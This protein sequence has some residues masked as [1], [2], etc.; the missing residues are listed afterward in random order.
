MRWVWLA[1]AA[2]FLGG[3]WAWRLRPPD[4]AP[5]E[6]QHRALR[7]PTAEEEGGFGSRSASTTQAARE[8]RSFQQDR[9]PPAAGNLSRKTP[10]A[11][12]PWSA[13]PAQRGAVRE[14]LAP[15]ESSG[16]AKA[17]A[18]GA[19]SG[20]L[21][22]REEPRAGGVP[23]EAARHAPPK[24]TAAPGE[25]PGAGQGGTG[26]ALAGRAP[27]GPSEGAG[28]GPQ[29]ERK[30][31]PPAGEPEPQESG[32][33]DPGPPAGSA[34]SAP[35]LGAALVPPRPLYAPLPEHPGTKVE[36]HPSGGFTAASAV[37]REGRV[38]VRLLVKA[39]GSVAGVDILASSGDSELDRA[40][41]AAVSRWRFD[42]ARWGGTPVD[43][44]YVVWV[45]FVVGP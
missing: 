30:D 23:R 15:R 13:K 28:S 12:G 42:P 20:S 38:R 4:P 29:A 25:S 18:R 10:P 8:D 24:A 2:L 26:P 33:A 36:I 21:D 43:S 41:V 35:A 19:N 40:A 45:R 9:K 17:H 11:G 32:P 6:V 44:Y 7:G 39:D 5:A 34:E 3:V 1:G 22:A 14:A 37:G 27:G 31:G 16:A